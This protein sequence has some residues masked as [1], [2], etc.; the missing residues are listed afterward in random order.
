L[1]TSDASGEHD[2]PKDD[3]E[4]ERQV[5]R[6]QP[7]THERNEDARSLGAARGVITDCT[8]SDRT[9]RLANS[10]GTVACVAVHVTGG[11]ASCEDVD[12]ARGVERTR[13]ED[14]HQQKL[15]FGN[16]MHG[17]VTIVVQERRAET[18]GLALAHRRHTRRVHP[19]G[20]GGGD[21]QSAD[22]GAVGQL[23]RR[24]ADE[25]SDDVLIFPSQPR[26]ST[27]GAKGSGD[28]TE[29]QEGRRGRSS[30]RMR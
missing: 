12:S 11:E 7:D 3:Y 10:L 25:I 28:G 1:D 17:D 6:R 22:E 29:T 9:R 13:Y 15:S 21:N 16:G 19:R 18:T 30:P 4:A 26:Q 23:I 24:Y 8:R 27:D 5:R 14:V 2:V 20:A